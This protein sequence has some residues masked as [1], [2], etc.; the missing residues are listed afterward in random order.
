MSSEAKD[1]IAEVAELG[2]IKEAKLT[3]F[4]VPK[5]E[6]FYRVRFHNKSASTD[7]DDVQLAVNGDPLVLERGKETI[8]R[9]RYKVCADNAAFP[10]FTQ[11]PGR[12]RKVTGEI[13]LFPYD[14]LG[15]ATEEE[16]KKL[17]REGNKATRDAAK[18]D[19]SRSEG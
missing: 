4:K 7:S 5:P 2:E 11:E 3:K 1:G 6:K 16:Y 14:L 13:H 8:I 9:E 19:V 12:N 10:T 17:L 18:K 15:E